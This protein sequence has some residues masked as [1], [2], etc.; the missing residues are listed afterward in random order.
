[1]NFPFMININ[2]NKDLQSPA[3]K[4]LNFL[5]ALVMADK[6]SSLTVGY[7][8]TILMM[9]K[10]KY[11]TRAATEVAKHCRAKLL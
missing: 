11:K 4:A 7:T 9:K 10:R 8:F 5:L 2:D 6:Y 3:I 1:M